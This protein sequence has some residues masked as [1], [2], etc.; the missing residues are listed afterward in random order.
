MT[1]RSNGTVWET[2]SPAAPG[3]G[4][5]TPTAAPFVVSEVHEGLSA[6]RVLVDT[7]TVI[8]DR[9]GAGQM[10]AH[11]PDNA[12]MPAEHSWLHEGAA[13]DPIVLDRL[14]APTDT[15]DLNAT[16]SAHGLLPK[17]SGNPAQVLKGD[18]TW[19]TDTVVLAL[20]ARVEEQERHIHE[21]RTRLAHHGLL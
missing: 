1:E 4:G 16:V 3:G 14:G 8:W 9:S 18:G 17:L 6:E 19:G 21:L 11:V 12:I 20:Q 13:S 5:Y 15:T 10:R 2:Y 7:D